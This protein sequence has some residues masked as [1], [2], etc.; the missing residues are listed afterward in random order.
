MTGIRSIRVRNSRNSYSFELK[1][2]ISILCGDSGRG[3]TTL[4]EMVQEYNRYGRDS[5]VSVSCDREVL[6]LEGDDWERVLTK[7][8]NKVVFIDED[9][10]FIRSDDFSR[11]VRG[12]DNYYL[13]IT[14]NYLPNLPISVDEI[15]ELSGK[16]NKKFKRVFHDVEKM[17]D[18]PSGNSLPFRPDVIITEDAKS[19]YR[20]FKNEADK[21]GILCVPADGKSNVYNTLKAYVDRSVVVIADGAAFG[22][23][24][25]DIVNQQKLTPKKLAIFLPES[26]EWLI[27]QSGTIKDIDVNKIEAPENYADSRKYMSW[28]Q[29]FTDLIVNETRNI[30]YMK[31][32]KSKL[33]DYYLQPVI[34]DAIKSK[35]SGIDWSKRG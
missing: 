19:G 26:F 10:E 23:E 9:S 27:L 13:L 16:K 20:F 31:Y 28:E 15:F 8:Q 12:S 34:A 25:S 11:L 7:T 33:P 4:F 32:V 17:Y 6:A 1:R 29:Y 35:A 2:N 24:I 14:R 3:K 30:K 22:A 18:S 5:G 21:L